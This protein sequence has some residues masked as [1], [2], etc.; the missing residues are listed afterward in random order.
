MA[1]TLIIHDI[2]PETFEEIVP[3]IEKSSIQILSAR[4]KYARCKGC[5]GCWLKTPGECVMH[6]G[7]EQIG[8]EI[9]TSQTVIFV[10]RNVYGGFSPEVKRI[11]DRAIPGVLP[12]FSRRSGKMHHA[13]RYENRP[14]FRVY[15]YHEDQM[16]LEEKELAKKIAV[17]NGINFNASETIVKFISKPSALKE[18]M[19]YEAI[20]P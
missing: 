5:F 2:D 6:D 13:T 1:K 12:F 16:T 17:A 3:S 14:A 15:F 10:S 11:F 8:K 20:T 9:V 7:L 4:K 19:I 18:E